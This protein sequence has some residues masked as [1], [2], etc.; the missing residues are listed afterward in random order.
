MVQVFLSSTARDLSECRRLAY[1]AIEGLLGYHCVRMEDF[2]AWDIASDELC[3]QRV[4][5]CDLFVILAGPLYGSVVESGRSYTEREYDTA[6]SLNIPCLCFLSCDDFLIPAALSETA[7]NRR[8]QE[9]FRRRLSSAKTFKTFRNS[10]DLATMVVQAIHNW[11]GSPTEHS[12]VRVARSGS[13]LTRE[14][15]RP[16]LRLGRNP[17]SEITISDDP[18]VSW[19]HGVI[20]K[21]AGEFYYRHLS[22]TN[23]AWITSGSR[24]VVLP[25]SEKRE[26]MLQA[27]NEVRV[28]NSRLAVEVLVSGGRQKVVPTNKQDESG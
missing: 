18:D 8:K 14:Y 16:F 26:V 19:D 25:P 15:R 23:P 10:S 11:E 9:A 13:G 7:S 4:G 21:H 24:Q 12:L 22:E 1:H 2:G 27:V 5:A 17:E 20:F 6:E 3:I 28:G